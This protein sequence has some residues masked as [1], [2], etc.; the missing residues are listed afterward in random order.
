[1]V[2]ESIDVVDDGSTMVARVLLG[3]DA[4]GVSP[5][6]LASVVWELSAV[7]GTSASEGSAWLSDL[8]P[9]HPIRTSSIAMPTSKSALSSLAFDSTTRR[10][11]CAQ[12]TVVQLI[13]MHQG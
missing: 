5:G 9:E 1:V 10:T 11:G 12:S 2:V 8:L 6:E 7:R 3:A 4:N 13:A